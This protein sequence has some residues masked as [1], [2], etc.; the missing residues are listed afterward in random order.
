MEAVCGQWWWPVVVASGGGQWWW[1]VVVASGGGHLQECRSTE[2]GCVVC[3]GTRE[4]YV[5][6]EEGTGGRKS[7]G[8]RETWPQDGDCEH[9]LVFP[10]L[11]L[12]PVS[13]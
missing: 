13:L 4:E 10:L 2:A 6:E 5:G 9:P 7:T 11:P 3:R 8:R 12:T 1:P